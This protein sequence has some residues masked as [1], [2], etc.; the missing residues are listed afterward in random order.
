MFIKIVKKSD[1]KHYVYLVEGYRDAAGKPRHRRIRSFGR[2]ED[3]EK[4][5]PDILAELRQ[6]AKAETAKKRR[7]D[8]MAVEIDLSEEKRLTKTPKN[9]GYVFLESLY[10]VLDIHRFMQTYSQSRKVE[11]S[12]DDIFRLLVFTRALAPASKARSLAM[13]DGFFFPFPDLSK[14][15]V[16]RA[17]DHFAAVKDDLTKHMHEQ[18]DEQFGRACRLVFYDVTNYYFESENFAGLRQKGVSKE[19]KKTGIVQMG[20]FLDENGIPI[21]YEL[22]P[23]NTND[24]TTMRPIMER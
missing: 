24:M 15:A 4:D 18:L 13:R 19:R 5:N 12:L 16:Y 10:R 8:L 11:H 21:T 17:L 14:D 6:W 7:Q 1:N 3:L 22:F 2:L 9:Y 23:G 20:L